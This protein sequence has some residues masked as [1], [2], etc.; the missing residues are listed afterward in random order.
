MR[1]LRNAKE[2]Y[3]RRART[4]GH[5]S[6]L[7]PRETI[8]SDHALGG[9]RGHRDRAGGGG[10]D[11]RLERAHLRSHRARCRAWCG[12]PCDGARGDGHAGQDD[13]RR[14][15]LRLAVGLPTDAPEDARRMASSIDDVVA[16]RAVPWLETPDQAHGLG[17]RLRPSRGGRGGSHPERER[18]ADGPGDGR[19]RAL[20]ARLVRRRRRRDAGPGGPGGGL[21]SS[22][23]VPYFAGMFAALGSVGTGAVRELERRLGW[24]RWRRWLQWWWGRRPF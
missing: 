17:R 1:A 8:A 14:T 16:S 22:S 18:R 2:L 10:R 4:R 11:H 21:F 19:D 23:A 7:V 5:R 13:G 12:R 24:I 15:P 6:R 9:A 3:R 20:A